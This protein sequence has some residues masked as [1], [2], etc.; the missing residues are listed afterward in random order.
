MTT[1]KR[2]AVLPACLIAVGL[3]LQPLTAWADKPLRIVAFGDSLVAGYG[4]SL[5]DALPEQLIAA[6]KPAHPDLEIL[7]AGVSGDTTGAALARLDWAFPPEVDG[8][9]VLLGGNDFLRG[10]PPKQMRR[11]LDAILGKLKARNLQVLVLGMKAARNTGKSYYQPFDATFP[12][13]AAKH[14]TLLEPFYLDGVAG[15]RTYNQID[16]IHPNA[17][18]VAKIVKRILPKMEELITRIRAARTKDTQTN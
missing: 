14:E 13:L 2:F 11:N 7:N 10:L 8:A 1:Q 4:L 17:K 3:W 5:K 6:L 9:I 15:T 18:G 16:G 12:E